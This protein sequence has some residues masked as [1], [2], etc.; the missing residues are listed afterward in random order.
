[1][2]ELILQVSLLCLLVGLSKQSCSQEFKDSFL[3]KHNELRAKHGAPPLTFDDEINQSAQKWA[4]HLVDT[5]KFFVCLSLSHCL[6]IS[7]YLYQTST[8]C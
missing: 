7:F 5:G 6:T 1:M 2:F 8:P 4:D 3:R